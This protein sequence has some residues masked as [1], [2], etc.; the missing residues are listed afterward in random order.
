MTKVIKKLMVTSLLVMS[1]MA[2]MPV[3]ASAEWKKDSEQRYTW[4][5]N[6]AK[7]TG[8]K[9]IN[10]NW[11]NF[12]HDG[13]MQVSWV[14]DNGNWYYLWSDGSMATNTWL[15]DGGSWFYF[16]STGKMVS[17]ST[18]IGKRNYDFNLPA[19]IISNDLGDKASIMT[20]TTTP[21]AVVVEK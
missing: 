10:G 19:F 15:N 12:R 11:Y 9:M 14:M 20:V 8:W 21:A 16:D 2:V 5:E 7:A 17:D 1:V 6:G 4:V 3:G 18:T 13:V